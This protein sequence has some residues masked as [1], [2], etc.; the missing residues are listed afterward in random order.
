MTIISQT[1]REYFKSLQIIFLALL[2]GQ[3]IFAAVAYWL[4]SGQFVSVTEQL[5][6][7]FIF[8]VPAFIAGGLAAGWL[9]FKSRI[10]AAAEKTSLMEKMSDYRAVLIIRFAFLE[11][12]TMLAVVAYLI[13]G[14][15]WFLGMAVI[16]MLVFLFL[17]PSRTRAVKD[18]QLN[19][20]EEQALMDPDRVIAEIRNED[21]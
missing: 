21:E 8:I 16:V 9:I 13:T 19:P 3:V 12:P 7:G 10:R 20:F 15:Q 14:N 2:A 6:S 1:S 5:G 4:R 11:G 17:R 18:L